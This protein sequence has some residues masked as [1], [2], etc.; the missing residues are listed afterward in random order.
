M[1]SLKFFIDSP[2]GRTMALGCRL[3]L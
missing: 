2:S 3:S 1:V